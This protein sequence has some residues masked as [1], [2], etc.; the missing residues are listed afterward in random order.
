M[1]FFNSIVIYSNSPKYSYSQLSVFKGTVQSSGEIVTECCEI[2]NDLSDIKVNE[3][4]NRSDCRGTDGRFSCSD[5]CYM[6]FSPLK[7]P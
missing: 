5:I 2:S 7:V 1:F 6:L 4:Q 3:Q